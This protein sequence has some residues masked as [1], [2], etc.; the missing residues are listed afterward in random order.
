MPKRPS[1][2][3]SH[4]SAELDEAKKTDEVCVESLSENGKAVDFH[5]CRKGMSTDGGSGSSSHL[6]QLLSPLPQRFAG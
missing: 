6:R 5:S 3:E 2:V 1:Y 4:A